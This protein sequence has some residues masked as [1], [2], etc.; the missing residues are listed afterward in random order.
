[1][2]ALSDL[3]VECLDSRASRQGHLLRDA[4]DL[5]DAVGEQHPEIVLPCKVRFARLL[6]SE[7]FESAG[8]QI[9]GS[10]AG[11]LIS[12]SPAGTHIVSVNLPQVEEVTFE[13]ATP[14]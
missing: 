2:E 4:Y 9:V 1:M 7:A 5:F 11:Y 8:I 12:R 14:A 13:C 10:N 6:E 3:A